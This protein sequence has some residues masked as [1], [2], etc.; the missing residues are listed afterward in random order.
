MKATGSAPARIPRG[1]TLTELAVVLAI[2]GL[3]LGSLMFTLS[4]QVE[5][6]N[7][8]ETRRRLEEA[9]EMV[10]AFSLVNGRLP[11]PASKT[12]NGNESPAGG[13]PCSDYYTGYF[14]AIAVGFQ[15]VDASGYALDAWGNRIRYAVSSTLYTA[16]GSGCTSPTLPHFTSSANLKT[17]GIACR[18]NDIVICAAWGAST[19]DCGSAQQVTNHSSGNRI[20][21]AVVWSHGKNFAVTGAGGSDEAANNKIGAPTPQNNHPVFVTRPPSP[22]G[23]TGGEFDD[24]MV[25]IPVGVLYSRMIAAGVLP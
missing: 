22:A 24:M 13:G 15:P 2:V 23:A 7:W 1:F 4:A 18:P 14:P 9:R 10:I 19:S 5:Q 6:R 8:E 20:V 3:L 17:N 21:A 11:C 25:W 16:A 12:S